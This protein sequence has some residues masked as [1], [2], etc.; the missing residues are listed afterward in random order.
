[1]FF[2]DRVGTIVVSPLHSFTFPM[3]LHHNVEI[4]ICTEGSVGV[5][6]NAETKTLYPGDLMI[7][8]PNEVHSYFSTEYGRGYMVILNPD[9]SEL[10]T[11]RLTDRTY[12]NF[13]SGKALLPLFQ[14]LYEEFCAEESYL[15]IYG[16]IHVILGSILK[17]LPYESTGQR[18]ETDLFAKALRYISRNYTKPIT[19]RSTAK[20]IGVTENHLS[21]IFS[22]KAVNGFCGYLQVLRIEHAKGL[23]KNT[24][25][26]V[27]EIL[28][29]SGFT[30]QRTFNRVFK[31]NTGMTPG[32]YRKATFYDAG[33][34]EA[35]Q[36]PAFAY[37]EMQDKSFIQ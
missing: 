28:L 21:R 31:E 25:K 19:L 7:A 30:N 16:Y 8:F 1:M 11:N 18:V 33:M 10:I 34:P 9:I 4:A 26:N 22:K 37:R 3:H 6:C 15:T 32:E 24:K 12:R 5:Q 17:R 13:T 14:R 29:E 23:L 2:E 27:Y 20:Q 36:E 35:R